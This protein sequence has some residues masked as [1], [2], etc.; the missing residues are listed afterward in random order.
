M[1]S[2]KSTFA[3]A[4]LF[5]LRKNSKKTIT[6]SWFE[7]NE[8]SEIIRTVYAFASKG[9]L[10][11]LKSNYKILQQRADALTIESMPAEFRNPKTIETLVVLK[12]QTKLVFELIEQQHPDSDI[13]YVFL[14]LFGTFQIIIGLCSPEKK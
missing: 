3:F 6:N 13:N 7:L 2:L 1:K 10:E 4:N 5:K 14:K 12:K 8:F 11:H 9:N